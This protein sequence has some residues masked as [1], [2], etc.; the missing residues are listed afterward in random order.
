MENFDDLDALELIMN[1]NTSYASSSRSPSL[2]VTYPSVT[3]IPQE[4]DTEVDDVHTTLVSEQV[5]FSPLLGMASLSLA[6]SANGP[7]RFAASKGLSASPQTAPTKVTLAPIV[8][9]ALPSQVR[10]IAPMPVMPGATALSQISLSPPSVRAPEFTPGHA[11]A[12]PDLVRLPGSN[13]YRYVRPAEFLYTEYLALCRD[14][15]LCLYE[16]GAKR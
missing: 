14:L 2:P 4:S 10:C 1:R 16:A 11:T 9:G 13:G 3:I 8:K 5:Q 15:L 6:L 12:F 7:V